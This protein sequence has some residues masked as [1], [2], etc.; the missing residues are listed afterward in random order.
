MTDW[1]M[2]V[3]VNVG[4]TAFVLNTFRGCSDLRPSGMME[5]NVVL[6]HWFSYSLRSLLVQLA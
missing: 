6:V 2:G 4:Q 5:K 3:I 1:F